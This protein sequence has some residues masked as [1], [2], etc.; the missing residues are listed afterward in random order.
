MSQSALTKITKINEQILELEK[1]R[2]LIREKLNHTILDII[3]HH[4]FKEID[5]DT[6]IGGILSIQKTFVIDD[7]ASNK[8]KELWK[9]EGSA[10]QK[11]RIKLTKNKRHLINDKDA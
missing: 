7:A 9:K 2:N 5:F 6:L 1:E 10:Y 11:S 8:Q 4:L 3:N